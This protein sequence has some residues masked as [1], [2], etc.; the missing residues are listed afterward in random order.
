MIREFVYRW[1][2]DD[3]PL[4]GELSPTKDGARVILYTLPEEREPN[5]ILRKLRAVFL[6]YGRA[7]TFREALLDIVW[8]F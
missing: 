8:P 4:P 5:A 1:L 7:W 2:Y 6:G 3:I